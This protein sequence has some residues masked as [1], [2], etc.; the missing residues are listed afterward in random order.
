MKCTPELLQ[1]IEQ[2]IQSLDYGCIHI[3]INEKGSFVEITTEKRVRHY[4]EPVS[5]QYKDG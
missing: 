2:A 3:Q 4:K 1:E 5:S